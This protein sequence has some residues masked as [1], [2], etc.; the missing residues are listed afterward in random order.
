VGTGWTDVS[1]AEESSAEGREL[2]EMSAHIL[3][4]AERQDRAAFA[5]V[6]RHFAPRLKSYFRRFGDDGG[7][8]EEVLQETF[9]A[10]WTKARQF[11]PSRASASTWIYTI[12]RNQ[13][14]DA[15][16]RERRPQFDPTDPAFVPEDVPDG[17]VSVTSR[18][19]FRHVSEAMAELSDEQREV[20]RLSFF[21]DEPHEAIARR[22]GLPIGTVKSRIRLAY[23]HLRTRLA[24]TSGGLL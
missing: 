15:F 18:E 10:V 5:A 12:A 24:P 11:D 23:G 14:I 4:V 2:D 22:L 17:E 6:F 16:R 20:L 21:E 13:R 7:R 19:R 8:A 1:K 9:A 3:A